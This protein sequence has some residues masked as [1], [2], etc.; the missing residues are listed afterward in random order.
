MSKKPESNEPPSRIVRKNFPKG[1]ITRSNY[2][3]RALPCL[4]ADFSNRCAYSM[5]HK[6]MAGGESALDVDH[7]DP[8]LK[9]RY[10][11]SYSNLFPASRHCNGKKQNAWPT[12]EMENAGIRFL[13]C[14]KEHDYGV[15]ILEDPVTHRV[16]GVTP[17]GRYHVRVL[18][19]NAG[20]FIKHRK[21]RADLH[22]FM[23]ATPM[24]IRPKP[25]ERLRAAICLA[26]GLQDMAIPLIAYGTPPTMAPAKPA[27]KKP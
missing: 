4:L 18:D 23:T 17:A 20:V 22:V 2:R 10:L 9:A 1:K 13:D 27:T 6:D 7:F 3:K 11:Q 25:F 24:V 19:L 21:M 26:K 12:K 14:T 5:L 15:H 16:F 8:R